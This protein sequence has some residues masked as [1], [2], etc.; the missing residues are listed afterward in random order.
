MSLNI[1]RDGI[2]LDF[3]QTIQNGWRSVTERVNNLFARS[4][5]RAWSLESALMLLVAI[6]VGTLTGFG[7][8]LFRLTL[9]ALFKFN[10]GAVAELMPWAVL[11]LPALGGL[12]TAVWMRIVTRRF[13]TG[14]GVAGIMEAVALHDGRIG[15]RGSIARVIGAILTIGFGGASGPEDPSVQ[16]GSTIGSLIG[17]RSKL[18]KQR[19]KTLVGCGAAAGL[20]AAFNAPITGVFFSIE[21]IL[22]GLSGI[23]TA[24]II[25]AAVAGSVAS[26][27][28]LGSA[29][30]FQI[31]QY[32]LRTPWELL[33]YLVLGIVAAL[34][35]VAYVF[36]LERIEAWF[37]AWKFTE[38]LKPAMGG[39]LVGLLGYFGS[40]AILGPGYSSIGV[41]LEGSV[42]GGAFFLFSLVVLKLIATPLTIGSGGQGGLFAPA[43]F[44]GAML[45]A[46]FGMV[47]STLFGSNIA[48]PPAYGLVGMGAVLAGAIR[49]PITGLLL[50]FEM[51]HDYRII[52]PLMFAVVVSTLLAQFLKPESVYTFKLKQRGVAIQKPQD[53]NLMRALTIEQA[54][55]S[56][57][58]LIILHVDDPI[59]R[60]TEAFETSSNHGF[61]VSRVGG[62]LYG[63]VTMSDMTRRLAEH[64]KVETIGEM[65][66]QN[67]ITVYP[68][69]TLE[70]ALRQMTVMDI[71]HLPVVE[72]RNP[73]RILGLLRRGDIVRA[74]GSA[75][76]EKQHREHIHDRLRMQ[77]VVRT[78]LMQVSLTESDNAAGK[79][80]RELDLPQ[81]C[82]IVAVQRGDQTIVPR[83][84]TEL[85]SGDRLVA[86]GTPVVYSKF[87]QILHTG[88]N[89]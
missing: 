79:R 17:E 75:M 67:V 85:Q 36:L 65:T 32:E 39:L 70:D 24:W 68:D 60:L 27:S 74:Y 12:I 23:S 10:F 52:L 5:D 54:M 31:P 7:V 80:I 63:V 86:L 76:I 69:E 46:G 53:P 22:G 66:T 35:A 55:T 44:L 21:I 45:G 18:A 88:P 82:V 37:E 50:P 19:V 49:A 56:F 4:Y 43:L 83:G 28:I 72:R 64:N 61:L 77:A 73:K 20:S 48:P 42:S 47:A 41:V 8:A 26:Q 51:T 30:A 34:V 38:W 89:T 87:L 15:L 78:E 57:Q 71:G 2:H 14:L 29:P 59:G 25:L 6:G 9:D 81:E 40:T 13:E 33:L 1:W 58:D 3:M 84:D 11:A 62:E 16:I